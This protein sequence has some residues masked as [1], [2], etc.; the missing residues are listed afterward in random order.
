MNLANKITFSRLIAIPFFVFFLFSAERVGKLIALIIFVVASLS[1]FLDGYLARKR[2]EVTTTGKIMDP[3]AD[4]ILVYSAFICFVY[5]QVIPFWMVILIV[6]RDF[7]IMGLRVE[8]AVRKVVMGASS[9]AKVKTALEDLVILL[10][11]IF[12]IL[13]VN[14]VFLPVDEL[15]IFFFMSAVVV[16]VI[17]SGIQYGYKARRYLG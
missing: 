7:L 11:L 12:F 13:R 2:M 10:V 3:V 6:A 16:T 9:L 17:I 14:G 4:K 8:L 1:D 5:M 15:I